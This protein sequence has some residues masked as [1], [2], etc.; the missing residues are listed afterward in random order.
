MGGLS[1]QAPGLA[2]WS[3]ARQSK[4]SA[5]KTNARDGLRRPSPSQGR[6]AGSRVAQLVRWM[7]STGGTGKRIYYLGHPAETVACFFTNL[8]NPRLAGNPH[9][10]NFDL[11]SKR[12][13]IFLP[14][15]NSLGNGSLVFALFRHR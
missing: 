14:F 11:L 3:N 5:S 13:L 4:T 15:S 9:L 6:G 2:V 1:G 8:E 7:W 12:F 10:S